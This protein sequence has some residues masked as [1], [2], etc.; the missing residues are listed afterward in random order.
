MIV[1]SGDTKPC[2][3][4]IEFSKDADV[5][6]QCCY[7]A[8]DE[9]VNPAFERLARHIIASSGQVGKIATRNK[10]RRLVLTHI[11]PKSE[12]MMCSL[13]KDVRKDYDGELVIGEDLMVIGV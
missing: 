11:R 5:L 1:I 9:I 4:L 10:V 7:L 12:A 2:E 3:E 13:V 8:E 6:I